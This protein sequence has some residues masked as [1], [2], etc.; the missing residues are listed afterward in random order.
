MALP[1]VSTPK[2]DLKLPS[3]G[4]VV[5]IRPFLVKEQKL[6]LHAIEMQDADQLNNALDDVLKACTFG[7][8]D[9]DALPVFDVE[10]MIMQIRARSVGDVVEI[11][12]VCNNH[13]DDKLLNAEALKYD[14]EAKE[15]RGEGVCETR[16]P[17]KVNL[18]TLECTSKGERPD[19]RIMFTEKIGVVMR[20]LPYGVYKQ[21]SKEKTNA[22]VSLKAMAAC[23]EMVINDE[24]VF[25]NSDFTEEELIGW[26]EELT[27]DDF[28][29][30]DAFIK[31]MP[32]MRI[33]LELTCPSCGAK[34]KVK[35]EGLDDFLV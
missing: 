1:S 8:V 3:N 34:E 7:K 2:F 19:N 30:M 16:I 23:V 32:T 27:G 13:V 26:I 35:L 4:A 15:V 11:N 25:T 5:K 14:P 6:V 33:E 24:E 12:Y 21:L 17:L 31:S 28:D 18:G 20:D 29:K 22:E 10:Y 9:I